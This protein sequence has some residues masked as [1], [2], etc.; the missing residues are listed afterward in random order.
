MSDI[1][2][3]KAKSGGRFVTIVDGVEAELTYSK[4][5]SSGNIIADHTG[6][7]A[8]IGG[9]GVGKDLVKFMIADARENGFKI[10][11]LCP[12]VRREYSKHPE[13][14]DVML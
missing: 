10:M 12:F 11:P 1:I 2:R 6:V 5:E 7:P 4:M 13:W 8:A 3:E 14:S 9:R